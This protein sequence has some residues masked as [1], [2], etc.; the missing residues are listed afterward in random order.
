[1][2]SGAQGII[3]K[4]GI[5]AEILVPAKYFSTAIEDG[6]TLYVSGLK[7]LSTQPL[8]FIGVYSLGAMFL[9][10]VGLLTSNKVITLSRIHLKLLVRYY[11]NC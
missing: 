2:P 6:K 3:Y 1:M 10:G 11:I 8:L 9:N 5:Y 4:L 7:L